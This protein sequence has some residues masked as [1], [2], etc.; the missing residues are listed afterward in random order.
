[1][2]FHCEAV[3]VFSVV[4]FDSPF[5]SYFEFYKMPFTLPT[6][7]LTLPLLT[8]YQFGH[9]G[10]GYSLEREKAGTPSTLSF[11]PPLFRQ[12]IFESPEEGARAN[13]GPR[14]VS[15]FGGRIFWL[16]LGY[17]GYFRAFAACIFAGKRERALALVMARNLNVS[18]VQIRIFPLFRAMMG[19]VVWMSVMKS[20]CRGK[21]AEK[22]FATF[23]HRH[24]LKLHLL[25]LW[26]I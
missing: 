14:P 10:Q 6:F 12:P 25:S 19:T 20:L 7:R 3:W 23:L 4:G 18:R 15:R 2:S 16:G 17:P 13:F 21:K 8:F 5:Y 11:L 22:Q 26:H 1:M 9:L 24:F